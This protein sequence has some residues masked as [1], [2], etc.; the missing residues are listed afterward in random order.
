MNKR[1]WAVIDLDALQHNFALAK[2]ISKA[3]VMP[4]IKADAY[5]HGAIVCARTL[6][7]AGADIFAVSCIDEALELRRAGIKCELLVLGYV[8]P[9]SFDLLME[10]SITQTVM[11]VEYAR[12]L[13]SVA[14]KQGKKIRV[15]IK[16][17][18]G[19]GRLGLY[20]RNEGAIDACTAEICEIC[21]LPALEV[22]GIYTHFAVSD[23]PGQDFTHQQAQ[24]FDKII[25]CAERR[26]CVISIKH[27][28]NSGAIFNHLDVSLDMVRQGIMLY[29]E[30]PDSSCPA[31]DLKSVMTLK[32]VVAFCGV[33]HKGETVSYGRTFTAPKDMKIAVI[34]VGYADGYNRALSNQ[35]WVSIKGVKCPIVGR[36]CMDQMMVDISD[37][38]DIEQGQEV[39][40][41]GGE[42]PSF[43]EL[44]DMCQTINYELMC[45]IG[46]RVP[47]MYVKGGKTVDVRS[48]IVE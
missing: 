16:L 17:D 15:H 48:R 38:P 33:L 23:I 42:G 39:S 43:T 10:E 45:A 28:A 40:L 31:L 34:P 20:A 36:V 27:C 7:E 35:G 13:S 18:T 47:R 2:S 4:V 30:K 32:S 8:A 29:G 25:E 5:G 3:R 24:L 11:S 44:A 1:T 9:E 12:K 26:G 41:I 46:V 19:M 22:E 21:S 14:D 37:C 6:V